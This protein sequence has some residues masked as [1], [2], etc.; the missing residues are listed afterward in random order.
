[1]AKPMV[2]DELW[3]VA[4]PLLPRHVPSPKGGHPRV[5]DRVCLTRV[6]FVLRTGLPWEDFPPAMGCSGMTPWSRLDEWRR[7]GVW[8]ALHAALLARL[9]GADLIDF[10]QV[11]VDSAHVRAVHAGENGPE[12]RGPPEG[13]EQAP[14]GRGRDRGPA[15]HDALGRGPE[16]RDPA[17]AAGRRDPAGP[18][19]ARGPAPEAE[20]RAGRLRVR[21]RPA[22]RGPVVPEHRHPDRPAADAARE[23]T[24]GGPVRGRA[25]P[26]VPA[27]VPAYAAPVRAAGRHARRPDGRRRVHDC[28][29]RLHN[30]TE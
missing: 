10:S 30:P 7:P 25:G 22:P 17:A 29:R 15:R 27:P 20:A 4:E 13:R 11:I 19:E 24:R 21:R 26:G 16:R 18:R 14:P 2:P 12:P 5:P 23:R 6:L 8:P 28:W 3:A 1:M 9:R